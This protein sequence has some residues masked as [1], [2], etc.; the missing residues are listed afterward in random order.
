MA[1]LE[2][3]HIL[4]AGLDVLEYEKSSFENLFNEDNIP[5]ALEDLMQFNQVLLSPHV[6]GWTAESH[7]KLAQTIAAK[8]QEIFH[9]V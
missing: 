8:V 7:R 1:A 2:T 9:Q 3:G 4:G 6:A 5:Q